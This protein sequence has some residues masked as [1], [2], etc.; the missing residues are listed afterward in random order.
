MK[1]DFICPP[2]MNNH[3]PPRTVIGQQKSEK[4]FGR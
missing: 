3:T 2:I 4:W 1:P